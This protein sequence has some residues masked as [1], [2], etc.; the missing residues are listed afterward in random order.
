MKNMKER[1]R[2]KFL[3]YQKEMFQDLA[4][5]I[6][7]NSV[8]GEEAPGL[9]F[10][11]EPAR[12]LDLAL[13]Q[14]EKYGFKVDNV[15]NYAGAIE[16]GD[17]DESIGV[18][19]HLDIVPAG[20][21]WA[22]DPFELV[23]KDNRLYGR[24]VLD[25]KGAVTAA[26]YGMRIIR[27]LGL[28][29]KRNIRLIIG[30]NEEQ[31]SSCMKYYAAHRPVPAMGFTPDAEYP[32][33]YGE[34]GNFWTKLHFA[35]EETPI[36]EIKGGVAF[37]AVCSE[38]ITK[39]DGSKVSAQALKDSI[40]SEDTLGYD[41]EVTTDADGN[42][43]LVVKGLAA[44]GSTP[45]I[46]VNAIVSTSIILCRFLGEKAGSMLFFVRDQ[47]RR[48][49]DGATLGLAYQDEISGGLSLNLG[50]IEMT[51][52]AS[53]LGIDIRYPVTS[54]L[55]EL[56]SKY[57]AMTARFGLQ[58]QLVECSEPHYVPKDSEVVKKLLQVYRDVT[59]DQ[60]ADAFTIG[61]GTY[62]KALGK[63]FVAFGPEF[64]GAEPSNVHNVDEH[65]TI[66]A[67]MDHCVICTMA[68]YELAK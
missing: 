46:G 54:S 30:T 6:S 12:V 24:G 49:P 42:V 21:G 7:V 65:V 39:L 61:G 34:K 16:Y 1:I 58:Y 68:M 55:S 43:I 67:F 59:G 45:E 63:Q 3:A 15:D 53:W 56:K 20:K 52:D 4:E 11:S 29:I 38:C 36:L 18:L 48:E 64:P 9:P 32:L 50:Y 5:I 44:H 35:A 23:I 13:K 19:A 10:G 28:P 8:R 41:A 33:I 31:G 25:N 62:A 60:N 47:I 26:L 2:E 57:E 27:D 14:G 66:D 51:A 17:F 40:Q 22:T 37:N